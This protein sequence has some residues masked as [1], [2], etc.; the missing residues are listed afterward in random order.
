MLHVQNAWI[1]T[2]WCLD[3]CDASQA[4]FTPRMRH[5]ARTETTY[6][7]RKKSCTSWKTNRKKN[8]RCAKLVQNLFPTIF[9]G[10]FSA[11][12]WFCSFCVA[13]LKLKPMRPT[14]DWATS[15]LTACD[16]SRNLFW[17]RWHVPNIIVFFLVLWFCATIRVHS[18]LCRFCPT[19]V[20]RVVEIQ[21]WAIRIARK[22]IDY[23]IVFFFNLRNYD[24]YLIIWYFNN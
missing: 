20:E 2:E 5:I 24:K 8:W 23:R 21:T 19:P 17:I 16:L 4:S 14:F 7:W 13:R 10:S 22:Y 11:G 9:E 12:R 6:F 1:S 18:N 15:N 3:V